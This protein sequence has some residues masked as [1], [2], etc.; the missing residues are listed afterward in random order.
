MYTRRAFWEGQRDT[1]TPT[2]TRTHTNT[3][4]N[5][6]TLHTN[7]THNAQRTTQNT[8]SGIVSSL[9]K[10]A[11]EGLSL[12]P[13]GSPKKPLDVTRFQYENRSRTTCSRFL[14]SF[15]L[16]AKIVQLHPLLRDTAEGISHRMVRSIF[17]H[18]NQSFTNNLQPLEFHMVSCFFC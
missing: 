14:Q 9:T 8:Q 4:A 12:D 16:P 2:P 15:T 11:N 13:R 1:P 7:N 17:R 6:H 18:Q 3:H 5:T 10:F